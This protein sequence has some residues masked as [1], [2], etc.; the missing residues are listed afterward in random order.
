MYFL[1]TKYDGWIF[2]LIFSLT[3]ME[4]EFVEKFCSKYLP[5]YFVL[6]ILYLYYPTPQFGLWSLKL[7]LSVNWLQ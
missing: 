5:T 3:D 2:T 7:N 6:Y 4:Q 1:A